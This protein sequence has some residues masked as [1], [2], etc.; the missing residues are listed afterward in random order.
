MSRV[1]P[2][3]SDILVRFLPN[4]NKLT[5]GLIIPDQWLPQQRPF[6][7]GEVLAVGSKVQED[8]KVGDIVWV[9]GHKS[10]FKTRA[11]DLKNDEYIV[12][13]KICI[14]VEENA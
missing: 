2:I 6:T 11:L 8:I 3:K 12:S 4:P 7:R 14:A 10:G 13:E 9:E 5:S 1:L